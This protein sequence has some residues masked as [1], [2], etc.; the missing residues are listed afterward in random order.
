M[1]QFYRLAQEVLM[2][3]QNTKTVKQRNTSKSKTGMGNFGG[4][5]IKQKMG[6]SISVMTETPSKMTKGKPPRSLA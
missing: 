1:F 3:S 2:K 5:A 4:T 6:R